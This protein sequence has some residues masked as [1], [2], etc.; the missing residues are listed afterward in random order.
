MK[1]ECEVANGV[2]KG[3]VPSEDLFKGCGIEVEL[4]SSDVFLKVKETLS[5]IGIPF[6]LPD[7]SRAL[8]Q[9]C[10]ILH[11]RGRYAIVHFKEMFILDGRDANISNEDIQRRNLAVKLLEKWNLVK[12][13]DPVMEAVLTENLIQVPIKIVPFAE[14]KNWKFRTKYSFKSRDHKDE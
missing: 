5:R 6:K 14:K 13:I 12:V 10:H 2:V 8:T 1:Q 9:S 11:K 7:G 3:S 4:S